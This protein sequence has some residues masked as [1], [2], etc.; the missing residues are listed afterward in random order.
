[1][2]AS[3]EMLPASK[4]GCPLPERLAI[5]ARA[6]EADR[7][8]HSQVAQEVNSRLRCTARACKIS[9]N[10]W[11][12]VFRHARGGCPEQI[13]RSQS[14]CDRSDLEWLRSAWAVHY[15]P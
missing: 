7:K 15:A 14:C 2:S 5:I 10:E 12:A 4:T 9:Q 8:V 1:M 11:K 3:C 13:L 6:S